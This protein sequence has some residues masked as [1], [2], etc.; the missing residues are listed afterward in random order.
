MEEE[1]GLLRSALEDAELTGEQ[2]TCIFSMAIK[3]TL[4]SFIFFIFYK[5]FN[6]LDALYLSLMDQ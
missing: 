3:A 5:E 4:F 1:F 6:L 2:M